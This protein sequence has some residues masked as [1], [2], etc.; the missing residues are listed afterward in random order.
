MEPRCTCPY[1]KSGL[2]AASVGGE[3]YLTGAAPPNVVPPVIRT[4]SDASR[5]FSQPINMLRKAEIVICSRS[6]AV[7]N[8]TPLASVRWALA[9]KFSHCTIHALNSANTGVRGMAAFHLRR[10]EGQQEF[11]ASL[12]NGFI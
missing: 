2:A 4:A 12:T 1:E 3:T 7:N 9:I 8:A 6:S 11:R 10:Y 5:N